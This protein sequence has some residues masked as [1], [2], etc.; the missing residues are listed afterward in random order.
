MFRLATKAKH[1][2]ADY[3]NVPADPA[4]DRLPQAERTCK[5]CGAVKITAF[6]DVGDPFRMW[7]IPGVEQQFVCDRDPDCAPPLAGAT[8]AANVPESTA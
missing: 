1:C 6:P 5:L 3:I 7:R 8:T 2:F 4:R